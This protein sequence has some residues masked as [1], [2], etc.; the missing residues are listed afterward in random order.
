M[1]PGFVAGYYEFDEC[2][3]DLLRLCA[4]CG[5]NFVHATAKDI[6]SKVSLLHV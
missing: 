2:H 5:A 6:D 4:L 3:V 1:L